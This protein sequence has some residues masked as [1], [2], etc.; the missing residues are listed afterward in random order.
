M[1]AVVVV[2]LIVVGL[3]WAARLWLDRSRPDAHPH[4]REPVCTI[5]TFLTHDDDDLLDP[6]APRTVAAL[7]RTLATRLEHQGWSLTPWPP[8]REDEVVWDAT[9][10]G[11]Q[12][13]LHLTQIRR[14]DGPRWMLRIQ[15]A[16]HTPAALW[17]S[18]VGEALVLALHR[19][20][21]RIGAQDLRWHPARAWD[22]GHAHV[23]WR[24]PA[25][26]HPRA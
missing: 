5:A 26:P 19:D 11:V 8:R 18:M 20:L 15:D 2:F 14:D 3:V 1:W 7:A 21:D 10:E 9:F 4:P 12:V 17:Q 23:W 24:R 25:P 6:D 16:S 13:V 22:A